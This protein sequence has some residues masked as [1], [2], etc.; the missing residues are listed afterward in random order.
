MTENANQTHTCVPQLRTQLLNDVISQ[1]AKAPVESEV[2]LVCDYVNY[3]CSSLPCLLIF[4]SVMVIVIIL[5]VR[6]PFV[7]YQEQDLK[8][9]WKSATRI[10]PMALLLCVLVVLICICGLPLVFSAVGSD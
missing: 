9:P 3:F 8:R 7:L 1:A 4:A 5:V 10:S 6:P 2:H